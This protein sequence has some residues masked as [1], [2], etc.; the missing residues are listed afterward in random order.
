M[1]EN[2]PRDKVLSFMRTR[3]SS[4]DKVSDSSSNEKQIIKDRIINF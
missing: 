3:L 2:R 4:S 1:T